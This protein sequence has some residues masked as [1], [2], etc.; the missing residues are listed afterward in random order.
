MT[1]ARIVLGSS[2]R[3]R[4]ELLCRVISDFEQVAPGIDESALEH[5]SPASQVERLSRAKARAVATLR[6]LAVVIASDQLATT[7]D[8]DILGKP[9]DSDTA[10]AQLRALSGKQARFLTGVCVLDAAAGFER[11]RMVETLIQFRPLENSDIDRYLRREQPFDCAGSFKS[12]GL[13][14]ALF[15]WVRSDDPTALVGL[16]MIATV[17][18]L[19]DAGI[20]TLERAATRLS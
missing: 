3:Y 14:I 1:S 16:P 18:L 10:T 8:G 5:E 4:A 12:E 13:G 2:S 7:A 15:E 6:P 9:G 17:S 19:R 11:Y 20:D